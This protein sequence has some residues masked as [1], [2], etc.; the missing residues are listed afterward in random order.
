MSCDS[1]VLAQ[2][3]QPCVFFSQVGNFLPSLLFTVCLYDPSVKSPMF[4][5]KVYEVQCYDLMKGVVID[6]GYV[7]GSLD[8]NVVDTQS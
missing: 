4:R 7:S 1:W 2:N 3:G 5:I 6:E 8:T